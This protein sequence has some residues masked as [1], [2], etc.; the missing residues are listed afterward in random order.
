MKTLKWI[1]YISAVIGGM[2][3][4]I[5]AISLITLRHKLQAVYVATYFL[6]ANSFLLV[7]ITIFLFI[8]INQ[9]KKE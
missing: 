4:L 1:G 8:Y 5:G 7:T 3:F 9:N 2:L 6:G